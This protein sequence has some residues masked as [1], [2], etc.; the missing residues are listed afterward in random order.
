M[1]HLTSTTAAACLA[2]VLASPAAWA[3][4]EFSFS[5]LLAD[6]PLVGTAFSGSYSVDLGSLAP[7][8]STELPLL[9]FSMQLGSA[10]YALAD[11]DFAPTAVFALGEF[12]GLS[13]VDATPVD[14]L[15]RPQ[16][17]FVPGFDFFADAYLA[18]VTLPDGAGVDS[19][20]GSYSVAVVPEPATVALLLAGLAGVGVAT[21]RRMGSS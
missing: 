19:G 15:V 12:V 20:F 8:A 6:G 13:F 5:G 7:G 10:S 16:I 2:M 17:A 11:A 4:T 1:R 14:L 9:S 21:R 3:S 18:Y